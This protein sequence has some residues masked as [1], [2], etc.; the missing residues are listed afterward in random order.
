MGTFVHPSVYQVLDEN[1]SIRDVSGGWPFSKALSL[2]R[3]RAIP[4]EGYIFWEHPSPAMKKRL[5]KIRILI[6][7]AAGVGKSSLVNKVLVGN[8]VCSLGSSKILIANKKPQSQ[9]SA[10]THQKHDVEHEI[11]AP[12]LPY[13][14]HDS[15]G[16]QSGDKNEESKAVRDF[17]K[18]RSREPKL[19]DRVHTIWYA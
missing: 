5:E 2:F 15:E 13:I 18:T 4:D 6:C 10:S 14:I 12:D 11:T 19:P 1:P 17:L 9:V 8:Y 16:F 7:G 3:H